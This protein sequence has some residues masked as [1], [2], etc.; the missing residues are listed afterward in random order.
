MFS[1]E[2][3]GDTA[4][5][6]NETFTVNLSGATNATIGD[7][8]GLGTIN[9][10]DVASGGTL[11]INDVSGL[12]NVGSLVFSVTLSSA[13]ASNVTVNY[14]T[15]NGTAR[16]GNGRNSD[17]SNRS[18]TLTFLPGETSKTIS[19]P[20]RN[21]AVAEPNETFFVN[22][23]SP[24]GA[25]ISDSQGIGTILNDDGGAAGSIDAGATAVANTASSA[26]FAQPISRSASNVTTNSA[27]PVVSD[28]LTFD[29]VTLEG[30]SISRIKIAV[31]DS[32]GRTWV[33]RIDN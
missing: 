8:S 20:I 22:L 11:S 29:A 7:S 16:G 26:A 2:I 30:V 33:T 18:G 3:F 14:A 4:V 27:G 10:D 13:S 32:L 24:V 6:A 1:V 21:D 25:T 12:E 19:V 28:V 31:G 15:A 23:S 5:E 9:N 17:Y